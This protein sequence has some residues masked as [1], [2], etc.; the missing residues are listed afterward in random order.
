VVREGDFDRKE[1]TLRLEGFAISGNGDTL[2]Y[3]AVGGL[4]SFDF[5]FT[6][7]GRI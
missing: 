4:L 7:S 1:I 2:D 6:S 3:S 5:V